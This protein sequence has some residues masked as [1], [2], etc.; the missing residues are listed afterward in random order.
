MREKLASVGSMEYSQTW[1][2][3]ATP[4]GRRLSV[5]T[6][7][8]R[9]ISD[10]E[11]T[12]EQPS[13]DGWPKTPAA[14]DG[15]G[16]TFDVLRAIREGLNPKAKLRDWALVAGWPTTTTTDDAQD[17]EK[18]KMRGEKWGFGTALSLGTAV[19]LTGWPTA[20]VNDTL[21]STHCYG[22]KKE[23]EERKIFLKLPGA[24]TLA[25]WAT[26]KASDGSNPSGMSTRRQ[27]AGK[28]PDS[29]HLQVHGLIL[30]L[31]RVPTGRRAVLAP[32]FSLWL[33]GYPEAWTQ[34]AP[35]A[36]DWQEAQAAL[37]SG[38]SKE[39]ETP[40]SPLW[41]PNL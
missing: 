17:M 24:A 29:L 27:E 7:S 31:F 34:A 18:R 13:V 19:R 37:E 41:P 3:S 28:A 23:G 5:H 21:G 36:K 33:M 38:C 9:R 1:K 2:E 8:G 14:C 26:A 40:S 25:G 10:S 35:G 20:I 16:G 39:A 15:E 4:A 30:D 11:S 6:A 32:E 12:G 22:P